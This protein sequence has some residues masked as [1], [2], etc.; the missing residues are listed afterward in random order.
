[1]IHSLRLLRAF[2]CPTCRVIDQNVRN[3]SIIPSFLR[4]KK[5]LPKKPKINELEEMSALDGFTLK[6]YLY[7]KAVIKHNHPLRNVSRKIHKS[8]LDKFDDNNNI[9]NNNTISTSISGI[10]NISAASCFE[11][12]ASC[13]EEQLKNKEEGGGGY[14]R[15]LDMLIDSWNADVVPYDD[16]SNINNSNSPKS[17]VDPSSEEYMELQDFLCRSVDSRDSILVTAY[18]LLLLKHYATHMSTLLKNGDIKILNDHQIDHSIADGNS[19]NGNICSSSGDKWGIDKSLLI[20]HS[21]LLGTGAERVH[22]HMRLFANDFNSEELQQ[23]FNCIFMPEILSAQ[24][25]LRKQPVWTKLEDKKI[26]KFA[27]SYLLDQFELGMKGRCV[28]NYIHPDYHGITPVD[29]NARLDVNQLCASRQLYFQDATTVSTAFVNDYMTIRREYW[30][31]KK[32]KNDNLKYGALFFLAT[33]VFD[34]LVM[35]K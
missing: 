24:L 15:K 25:T 30:S 27:S 21:F 8:L 1:M 2:D 14:E 34:Y 10:S 9:N 32:E 29:E 11:N 23:C 20:I 7:S 16:T 17:N 13:V 35:V 3:I 31:N 4:R 22:T 12:I 28:F 18:R 19:M 26:D 6:M 5:K 33:C